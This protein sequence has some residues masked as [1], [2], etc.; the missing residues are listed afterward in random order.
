[1]SST[2]ISS[3]CLSACLSDRVVG[4]VLEEEGGIWRSCE[5]DCQLLVIW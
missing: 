3:V 1:M 2:E 5:G 4:R